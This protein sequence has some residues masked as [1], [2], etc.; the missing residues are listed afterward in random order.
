MYY[1]EETFLLWYL[2]LGML[3]AIIW[4]DFKLPWSVFGVNGPKFLLKLASDNTKP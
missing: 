2:P 3:Q 4:H 1:H